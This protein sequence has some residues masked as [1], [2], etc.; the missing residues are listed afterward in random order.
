MQI[1]FKKYYQN[2][3]FVSFLFMI[4]P[5]S[6]IIGNLAINI[7]I[8]LLILYIFLYYKTQ[9]FKI[10][11]SFLDKLI[12]LYFSYCLF[13]GVFNFFGDYISYGTYHHS[14]IA[15]TFLYLRFLLLYF[16]IKFIMYKNLLN[17]K[18]FIIVA[19][20][21][22][23]F[24]CLDLTIQFIYGKDIFGYTSI[25]PRRHGGPFGDELIAGSYIQRFSIFVFFLFI[26]YPKNKISSKSLKISLS[27][28]L[29][30]LIFLGLI[31]SGNRVPMFLFF[32]LFFIS[33][34]IIKETRKYL[35]PSF[36][37]L[38]TSLYT[39]ININQNIK[40]HLGHFN[41]QLVQFKEFFLTIVIK[42]KESIIIAEDYVAE[43]NNKKIQIPNVYIK[44]FYSGYNSWKRNIF[45]GG[46][47][48]SFKINC[49][50][51]GD[52]NC[53]SHPHNYYLEI[54]SELGLIGAILIIT[55]FFTI[56]KKILT[57]NLINKQKI[58]IPFFCLILIELFPLR[59]TGSFF[60]TGNA[61]YFFLILSITISLVYFR[62]DKLN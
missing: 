7:N 48:K 50:R 56:F 24:V 28:F 19:S 26:I 27:L 3:N 52:I 13:V 32:L 58:I 29:F 45:F 61:T 38:I 46:G 8:I 54:L 34:A 11:L 43:I 40:H 10:D 35:I 33:F 14:Y 15:K 59:T 49:P 25:D 12:I 9:T 31:I 5:I 20:L 4:L 23:I 17:I 39:F 16:A 30:F 47:I 60:T 18:Y 21:C 36:F 57:K 62:K 41:N 2:L 55:I 51:S 53:P 37:I 22:S 42:E 44:E 6:F 1:N